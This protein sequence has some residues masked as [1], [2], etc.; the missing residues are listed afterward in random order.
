VGNGSPRTWEEESQRS[1]VQ[2]HPWLHTEFMTSLGYMGSCLNKMKQSKTKDN[3]KI[4]VRSSHN[5]R[6]QTL[7]GSY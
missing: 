7:A 2:S 3:T 5:C 6:M 4:V 1:G